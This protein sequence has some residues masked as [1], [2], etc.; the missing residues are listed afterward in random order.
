MN[1]HERNGDVLKIATMA[2]FCGTRWQVNALMIPVP[3]GNAFL[4]PT[5]KIMQLYKQHSGKNFVK[6]TSNQ[7]QLDITASKT[8]N[9]VFL[10]VV[11]ANR[12]DA[13]TAN[14]NIKSLNIKSA[15][16][17]EISADPTYEILSAHN[18]LLLPKEK[19]V[20]P[21]QPYS[22]TAASVTVIELDT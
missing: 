9:T 7:S 19:P 18:D 17:W 5:A 14:I 8:G 6:A 13:L 2:D 20:T 10:H 15:R 22:F 21:G 16:A 4:M 11:N 12:T 3:T 1:L